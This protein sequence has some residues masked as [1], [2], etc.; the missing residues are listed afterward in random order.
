MKLTIRNG[1]LNAPLNALIADVPF[2]GELN[3]NLQRGS[4]E[5]SLTLNA[6]NVDAGKLV[7]NLTGLE[8][9]RGKFNRIVFHAATSDTEAGDLLNGLD[10]DLKVTGAKLSYGNVAGAQPV[11]FAVDD[12][13]LTIPRGKELSVIARGS[14]LNKP[15]AV[16]FTADAPGK[17]LRRRGMAG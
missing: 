10:I 5:K 9:I 14:L 11:N 16:K 17:L 15:F 8:G 2:Q 1:K 7:D 3:M 13:A 12:M 6:R 4:P